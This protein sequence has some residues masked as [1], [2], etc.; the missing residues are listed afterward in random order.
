MA[1]ELMARRELAPA[2][3]VFGDATDERLNPFL[4]PFGQVVEGVARGSG[5]G[6]LAD[7]L[8]HGRP[9]PVWGGEGRKLPS[10]DQDHASAPQRNAIVGGVEDSTRQ[11]V[12][13]RRKRACEP[14]EAAVGHESG[15]AFQHDRLRSKAAQEAFELQDQVVSVLVDD[16]VPF[17]GRKGG[18]TLARRA[19]GEQVEFARTDAELAEHAAM[20]RW[21]MSIRHRWIRGNLAR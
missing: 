13:Q 2:A 4:T 18:E 14:S 15:H 1:A 16:A 7:H 6:D 12:P 21:R 3:S 11:A 9:L 8:T 10:G 17:Q 20:L 5:C 19:S